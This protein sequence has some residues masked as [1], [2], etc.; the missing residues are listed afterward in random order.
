MPLGADWSVGEASGGA[1]SADWKEATEEPVVCGLV[2]NPPACGRGGLGSGL[3]VE[4]ADPGSDSG[5]DG[6][7]GNDSEGAFSPAGVETLGSSNVVV[8]DSNSVM[9]GKWP[10]LEG[11]KS[12]S[13]FRV[14]RRLGVCAAGLLLPFM[15][16]LPPLLRPRPSCSDAAD[17]GDVS[18][19]AGFVV[20]G[21]IDS[22]G[23][24]GG[25]VGDAREGEEERAE[26]TE[27]E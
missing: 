19:A 17:A 22:A 9:L 27:A 6:R 5:T 13:S 4:G 15:L 3:V 1:E 25:F 16:A 8:D 11:E 2:W 12:S 10:N 24:F 21:W 7:L 18:S 14:D 20:A 26:G 23:G